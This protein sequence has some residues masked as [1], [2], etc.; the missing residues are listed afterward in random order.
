MGFF[1]HSHKFSSSLK[2]SEI[3]KVEGKFFLSMAVP[4]AYVNFLGQGSDQ[5]CSC[6]L[7]HSHSHTESEPHL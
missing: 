3:K 2:F 7:H 6:S 1:F 4:V 5:R